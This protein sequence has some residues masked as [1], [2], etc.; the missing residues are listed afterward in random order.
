MTQESL[1]ECD[2]SLQLAIKLETVFLM[3]IDFLQKASQKPPQDNFSS[4]TNSMK[5]E[6]EA[7]LEILQEIIKIITRVKQELCNHPKKDRDV[8]Y[9]VVYCMNCNLSLKSL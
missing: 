4:L 8:C 2:Y 7:E 3:K 6:E 9:G 1:E 5:E